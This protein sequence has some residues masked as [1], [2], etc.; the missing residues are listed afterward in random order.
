MSGSLNV[1]GVSTFSNYITAP[2][3]LVTSNIPSS[4][5]STGYLDYS[6]GGTRLFSVG[7]SGATKG[8]F[9]FIAKGAD[10]SSIEP[11]GI[12]ATGAATFSSTVTTGDILYVGAG[13]GGGGVWTWGPTEAYIYSPTS[14]N[15]NLTTDGGLVKGLRITTSGAATFSS[16]VTATGLNINGTIGATQTS[17]ARI[18]EWNGSSNSQ[19]SALNYRIVRHYPV[20]SSGSKLII[21]FIDQGNLN[22]ST[23]VRIFGHGARFNTNIPLGFTAD[24]ALGHLNTLA[25]LSVF[26]STGNISGIAISGMNIEI[27]FTTAYTATTANGLFA[28]IDYMTNVPGHSINVAN[29]A[30]N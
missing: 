17:A 26:N 4:T 23:I 11:L 20:V 6:G 30:M 9:R 3:Y 14:K 15:L 16:T 27:S 21:P 28:T 5:A 1:G 12:S 2:Y 19:G 7:T 18:V 25:N 8:T 22:S 10:D 24:F 29:I 13:G